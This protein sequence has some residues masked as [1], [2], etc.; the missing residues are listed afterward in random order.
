MTTHPSDQQIQRDT[1][2][3]ALILVGE[4]LMFSD[5]ED[6]QAPLAAREVVR[7]VAGATHPARILLAGPR[8][9]LLVADVPAEA[10]VDVLVRGL[11]DA[12]L[13]GDLGGLQPT[14]SLYCGGIDVFDPDHRYDLVVALGGA[15]RL[16]GPDSSGMTEAEVVVALSALLAPGG[17]LVV[18][19]ANELGV[20]DLVSAEPDPALESD[21]GWTV[22]A[23]GFASRSLYAHE[24]DGVLS[25]AGLRREHTYAAL[26]SFD[27]HCV[28]VGEAALADETLH[29]RV[30]IAGTGAMDDLFAVTPLLRDPAPTLQ[31]VV[32]ARLLDELAPAWLVVAT[33]GD[34]A[35]VPA[36]P[37]LVVADLDATTSWSTV[38]VRRDAEH[39]S[40]AWA[41]GRDDSERRD[42][43][44]VRDLSQ[45]AH[46]GR[47]FELELRRACATRRH[48]PVRTLVRAYAA[49]L[50]DATAW[51]SERAGQRFF[52]TPANTVLD[53]TGLAI[54]DPSWTH[55]GSSSAEDALVRGL[56]DFARRLLASGGAH[57]WRVTITPDELTVTL[58]AMTGLAVNP[59]MIA[60]AARLESEIEATYRGNPELAREL[61]EANLQ[62][63]EHARAL[64]A[65]DQIGYRELLAHDRILSREMREKNGQVKWLEGT[66]R[67][68]DRYI[69][70]LER[71]IEKYE[72]TL[73]YRAV[74]ALRA[75]RRIATQKAISAAKSTA[76]EALPPGA[77]SKARQ[78][79][80]R[81]L[82]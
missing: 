32:D 80:T 82:K 74:E 73:T 60:H 43:R 58:G 57:P 6:L 7:S 50:R 54:A 10:S 12:R 53:G 44:L 62:I 2:S 70:T 64:P 16:L 4:M 55:S 42:G 81:A 46:S 52:A 51:P 8:A 25:A 3:G 33:K 13:I 23:Q 27:H 18:D 36:P 11:P 21:A 68:R 5:L 63:G 65:P 37:E 67:H 79:A 59:T 15:R 38:A 24:R 34:T 48:A 77:L 71:I 75:P 47:P 61:F 72:E 1:V 35:A 19:L 30:V 66:L 41:D 26:P 76:Q 14:V 39:E 31:R 56:R 69:R 22:G 20:D 29:E 9:G 17:R 45:P 78:L 28:L 40:L 49:W